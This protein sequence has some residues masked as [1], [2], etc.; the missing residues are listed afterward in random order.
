MGS[1]ENERT[2]YLLMASLLGAMAMLGPLSIDIVLPVL[3]TMAR[4]LGEPMGRI[5]WSMTAIFTGGAMGQLLFGPL[6]DRY[7]RKP[8]ILIA[9]V[10]FTI[11]TIAVSRATTLEPIIFWRFI[12]GL[13]MAS[14]R[15]I[16]NAAARDQ[17]DRE[18]LGKL[19][20]LIFLVS[21]S[22]SVV[23]PLIGG[24]MVTYF[25]WQSVFL[26]MTGYG[27]ALILAVMFFFTETIH[28]KDSTALRPLRIL[29]NFSHALKNR[30]FKI[31]LLS[32]GFAVAGFV[33]FLSASSG[34]AKS[35][36]GLT[37]QEY[38]YAFAG[39]VGTF[40]IVSI[41]S[42]RFVERVGSH[43][44]IIIGGFL[45]AIGGLSMLV[46]ALTGST[47]PI[48]LFGPMALFVV[49]F[50][51]LYPLSTAKALNPFKAIA[52]T[53]SSLLGFAQ[54]IMGATVSALLAAFIDGT[55]L[56]MALALAVSGVASAGIYILY[57]SEERPAG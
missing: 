22:A 30:E 6:S 46:F 36:F 8:V 14:G 15:I 37:A 4:E 23:N 1:T 19:I 26:V 25:G 24:F 47:Q 12:Q 5:E 34:V 54:N 51:F 32:G 56:P 13:V 48:S 29:L 9:L 21:V 49:G 44:F 31:C 10:L 38:S 2:A 40:L 43:R 53:A 39:V 45:E 33:A 52:G 17:F 50:S 41:F 3:P 18:R 35:A 7:G 20:S 28:Q 42:N 27:V 16:A 55:A 57:Q 11:S